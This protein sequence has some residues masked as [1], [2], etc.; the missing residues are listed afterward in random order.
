MLRKICNPLRQSFLITALI[1]SSALQAQKLTIVTNDGTETTDPLCDLSYFLPGDNQLLVNYRDD[2]VLTYQITDIKVIIFTEGIL[3]INSQKVSDNNEEITLFPNPAE[4][5]FRLLNLPAEGAVI[6]I[7][8]TDG[9]LVRQ[10]E[11]LHSGQVINIE[12]L[13]KGIY[14]IRIGEQLTK[15]IKL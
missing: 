1:L 10:E 8:K 3:Q 4:N 7:Y 12:D 9:S 6:S 2:A 11:V 14:L 5:E 15:L 13:E